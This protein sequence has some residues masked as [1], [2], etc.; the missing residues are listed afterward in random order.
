VRRL[1]PDELG[2]AGVWRSHL[3]RKASMRLRLKDDPSHPFTEA[4]GVIQAVRTDATGAEVVVVVN[5]RGEEREVRLAD[6]LAA[7]VF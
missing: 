1:G 7:K 4:I 2:D 5:R 6:V 3:G